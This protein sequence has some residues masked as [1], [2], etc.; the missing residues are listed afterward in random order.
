MFLSLGLTV[1]SQS[2]LAQLI[3]DKTLGNDNSIVTPNATVRDL[4][5]SLIEGGAER[6]ANLFHSFREFNIGNLERV[7]FAN[8]TGVERIFSRVTGNSVSNIDGVLGVLGNADLFF[9]NPNGI[10]FG[11]NAS[12]DINSSFIG[13]TADSLVFGDEFTFSASNPTDVPALLTVNI[14][15]GLQYGNNPGTI[16][17]LSVANEV[18]LQVPTNETLGLV[19]GDIEVNGGFISAFGGRV[20]LGSVGDNNLVTIEAVDNGY[21]FN[22]DGVEQFQDITLNSALVDVSGDGGGDLQLQ[23]KE[24]SLREFSQINSGTFGSE[25]GGFALIKA[26]ESIIVNDSL[27]LAEVNPGASGNGSIVTIE[28]EQLKVINGGL[29]SVNTLGEGKGGELRI[30]VDDLEVIGSTPDGEFPSDVSAIV[31]FDATGNGGNLIIDSER[32][33]IANGGRVSVGVFGQGNAGDLTITAREIEISGETSDGRFGS[34]LDAQVN[35][36]GIGNGGNLVIETDTLK[37]DGGAQ[38]SVSVFGQGNAGDLTITA[39]EIEVLGTS[40]NGR[41]SSGLFADLARSAQ[42]KAGSIA[43]ETQDLTLAN[44]G[45]ISLSSFGNGDGGNLD[46]TATKIEII[47]TRPNG[48]FSSGLFAQVN[49]SAELG[50]EGSINIKTESLKVADGAQV[51]VGTDSMGNIGNA[52]NLVIQASTIEVIGESA[53]GRIG[54]GI[55]SQISNP[56]AT[57]NSGDLIIE[58]ETLKVDG[59]ALISVSNFGEGKAGNL[60]VTA[61]EVKVL[62]T[63]ADG[64]F[65][66]NL[67]SVSNGTGDGGELT[68]TTEKLSILDGGEI[69]ASSNNIGEAGNLEINTKSLNLDDGAIT[70]ETDAGDGGNITLQIKDLLLLRNKSNI[71]T[72]AGRLEA[73]GDGGDITINS[74]LIVA[75]PQE[76]S[77]ITANAFNGKG[78]NVNITTQGIFGLEFRTEQTEKSDITASS[79]FGLDGDV[80]INTPDVNPA[81]GLVNLPQTFAIPPLDTSCQAQ[82][83]SN[84]S[85]VNLGRGGLPENSREVRSEQETWDDLRPPAVDKFSNTEAE[86]TKYTPIIEAQSWIVGDNGNIFLVA[87]VDSKNNSGNYKN[88]NLINSCD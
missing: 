47:G 13:S 9:L 42:G 21:T 84:S 3:P 49:P 63:S 66:S 7:Y 58:T 17:N 30:A 70:A 23:A 86:S 77:D 54:S 6:G 14:L 16:S 57:G 65:S 87:N 78:G 40:P 48:N 56:L 41:F 24:I 20:E 73:G 85:F 81:E 5:A 27:I 51:S 69:S 71:S 80:T 44:G 83:S 32:V 82:N 79:E 46:I 15:P 39:R 67:S 11:Q 55:F 76:N 38:V 53:D 37:V 34:S 28:T 74:D 62:G 72:T 75:F 25:S 31:G 35:S 2:S 26:A 59:G 36:S 64:I 8:P 10:I 52:G 60:K 18:G 1:E 61:A 22:Y 88:P 43:I 68:I 4:P 12:L 33:T 50:S 29:I 19:G 45:E